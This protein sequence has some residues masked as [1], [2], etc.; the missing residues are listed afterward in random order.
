MQRRKQP[1]TAYLHLALR[2]AFATYLVVAGGAAEAQIHFSDVSVSAGITGGGPS[3]G[4]SWGDLNG[5]GRPD[6]WVGNHP[7]PPSLY[8]N[9]GDG[10]FALIKLPFPVRDTHGAAWGDFDADGDQDLIQVAGGTG[11]DEL[12]V[13]EGGVLV[14]QAAQWGVSFKQARSRT[15]L[16]VDWN[17]DGLLDLVLT[18][19]VSAQEFPIVLRN[20]GASFVDASS[21][22]GV[23]PAGP[24]RPQLA[25]LTGDGRL[26]LVMLTSEL[27]QSA[28]FDLSSTPFT[29]V[30]D[31]LR[32]PTLPSNT[33]FATD[34][35]IADL[36]GD[37]M[38]DIFRPSTA[39]NH[40]LVL[41]SETEVDVRLKA[42]HR[43]EGVTLESAGPLE[44]RA[45]PAGAFPPNVE[46]I[47]IG[48]AG[49]GTDSFDFTLDP[50]DPAVWGIADHTPGVDDGLFVG[51]E[52]AS[53]S[54]TVLLSTGG[55]WDA[56]FVITS[57]LPMT[58]VQPVGFNPVPL[59]SF[60]SYLVHTSTGY[61]DRSNQSGLRVPQSCFSAVG[62]DFDNDMD[63]DLYLACS[64]PV[65]NAPN[66][67]FENLGN[68]MFVQV[69][70]G[71]GAEG[72]RKGRSDTVI[73]A[74]YDEDG[75]LD[76]FVTNGEGAPPFNEGG[77]HQLFRNTGNANHWLEIDL[78]GRFSNTDGIGARVELAAGGRTQ[79]REQGGGM[80]Y[81]AQNYKRL[82]FGLG[83]NTSA[84]YVT[85]RWPSGI[86]QTLTSV[87]A[88][89][90]LSVLEVSATACGDGVDNDQDG[91]VD[92]PDDPQCV[93]WS[94]GSEADQDGDG[95][96]DAS[97]NCIEVA[98]AD[99]LDSD[100]D[101]YG[102]LCDTDIN[103]PNDG[104]TNGLDVSALRGQFGMPGGEADFNGDG[105]VNGLD[106]G[107][108]RQY[109]GLPPGPSCCG[110]PLP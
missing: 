30:L 21:V 13:N 69:P 18:R 11:A 48:A 97:D 77:G 89:Q 33:R 68:G 2:A 99:Q 8:L 72:T 4:A 37:L 102:N 101:G 7:S 81:R 40:E 106:V 79:V 100:N 32:F 26:D 5:D 19:A 29:N 16:W 85:I 95:I 59:T 82:H 6:I 110:S 96:D 54:W 12:F 61:E 66:M 91:F 22:A 64:W 104:T 36:S 27:S 109:F 24:N 78:V 38:N 9:E 84:D 35:V 41:R 75:F 86:E 39:A 57:N 28:V 14:D 105:T 23:L 46:I 90:I 20:A 58:N 71:G 62:G 25:D 56:N 65:T 80:H 73:M 44:V 67:L 55:N 3:F 107:I 43:E 45:F 87:P 70:E 94:T 15:P 74:D 53:G 63:I 1:S 52:P 83:S 50:S 49:L 31:S 47:H 98:N 103:V 108:M 51:Y 10:T 88:D 60:P 42:F 76:L 93:S 34:E 92:F 17:A